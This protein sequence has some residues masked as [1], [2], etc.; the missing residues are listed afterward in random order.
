MK[1]RLECKSPF[2]AFL[3]LAILFQASHAAS[4]VHAAVV[5]WAIDSQ[6]SSVTL[7]F[8]DQAV[9]VGGNSIT[10]HVANQSGGGSTWNA[11]NSSPLA[12]LVWTDHQPTSIQFLPGASTMNTPSLASYRPDPGSFF[13]G[14]YTTVASALADFGGKLESTTGPSDLMY[15]A[16]DGLAYDISSAPLPLA[17]NAFSAAGGRIGHRERNGSGRRCAEPVWIHQ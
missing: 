9:I 1:N 11:G 14:S 4:Q 12:G 15:F 5:S 17:G 3:A 13:A 2:S 7:V 6:Q 10:A 16:L 8:P